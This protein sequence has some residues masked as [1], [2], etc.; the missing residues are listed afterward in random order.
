MWGKVE[1]HNQN[2]YLARVCS[3][4]LLFFVQLAVDSIVMTFLF[5]SILSDIKYKNANKRFWVPSLWHS[6]CFDM[7]ILL[8]FLAQN[9]AIT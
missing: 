2:V 5:L 9:S 3:C 8:L 7:R 4:I 6:W 1:K